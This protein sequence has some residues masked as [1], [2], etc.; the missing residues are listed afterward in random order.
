MKYYINYEKSA[1]CA[2]NKISR[3]IPKTPIKLDEYLY[4]CPT[5][6]VGVFTN[7]ECCKWCNQLLDWTI[8]KEV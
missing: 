8:G 5:C 3:M 7:S 1:K 2:V 6:G 4:T